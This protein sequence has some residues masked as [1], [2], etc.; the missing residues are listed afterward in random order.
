MHI[1][2]WGKFVFIHPFYFIKG[3]KFSLFYP[4]SIYFWSKII[5]FCSFYTGVMGVLR[6]EFTP[7]VPVYGSIDG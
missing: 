7:F 5:R 6:Y 2:V 4:L 3:G 1:H